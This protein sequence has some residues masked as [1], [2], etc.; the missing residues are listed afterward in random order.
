MIPRFSSGVLKAFT[1]GHRT[2]PFLSNIY[3]TFNTRSTFYE[4]SYLQVS[5]QLVLLS[6]PFGPNGPD[7]RQ[8]TGA[9]E[10]LGGLVM[11]DGVFMS[12]AVIH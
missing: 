2:P 1:P 12:S 6:S 3:H 5:D 4:F 9:A 8:R 10:T 7:I 11:G